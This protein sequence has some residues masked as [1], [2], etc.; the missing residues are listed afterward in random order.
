MVRPRAGPR[1]P[2]KLDDLVADHDGGMIHVRQFVDLQNRAGNRVSNSAD[3]VV[4]LGVDRVPK[5]ELGVAAVNH[6]TAIRLD[7]S[8]KHRTLVGIPF[9][10]GRR[11]INSYRVAAQDLK[12]RMQAIGR[13]PLAAS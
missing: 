5:P 12:V 13:E 1:F 11:R 7:C 3:V 8:L 9:G 4:A 2:A 10:I 6:V